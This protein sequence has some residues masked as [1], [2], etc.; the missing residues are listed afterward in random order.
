[1]KNAVLGVLIG[2]SLSFA[3]FE[4]M[5]SGARAGGMAGAFTAVADDAGAIHFNPA[6]L[7]QVS[8]VNIYTFYELLFGGMGENLHS[9]TL[10]AAVPFSRYGTLGVSLQEAGFSLSSER[11][12]TV[13]YGV[14]LL[15]DLSLGAGLNGYNLYLKDM[16][17]AFAFGVD[18][19]LHARIYRRWTVGFF[20]HNLNMPQMGTVEKTYLPRTLSIG[21]AYEPADGITSALDVSKTVGEETRI[22]V[23]GEFAIVENLLTLRAGVQ[24]EPVRLSVGLGTGTRNIHLDYAMLTHSSLP[25]THNLGLSVVF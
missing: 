14:G 19:G 20:A 2:L 13:G 5:E 6:G 18:L 21:L 8:R 4:N 17:T 3:I 16:G 15:K 11:S 1:V 22:A 7:S 25:L 23:G 9:A 12:L 10:N 24:T